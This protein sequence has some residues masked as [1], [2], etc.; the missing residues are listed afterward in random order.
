[1]VTLEELCKEIGISPA[2]GK[3][4]VRLEK[5]E[6]YKIKDGEPVFTEEYVKQ[7][8]ADIQS[9]ARDALKSRRNKKYVS[10]NYLYH[11]YV[12]SNCKNVTAVGMLIEKLQVCVDNC[13]EKFLSVLVADCAV[14]LMEQ[15]RL[16]CTGVKS[17]DS[18]CAKF[19]GL[20][21]FLDGT[22]TF[23]TY[24]EYIWELMGDKEYA[25]QC[26]VK[27][28]QLFNTSYIYEENEDIL[29]LIYISG[30]S[31]GNRK[32]AG[33]YYTPTDVVRRIMERLFSGQSHGKKV[34]DPCCGT[35]NFL[36]QLPKD[37][38]IDE[39]Y[40]SDIDEVSVKIARINMVLKFY[41]CDESVIRNHIYVKDNLFCRD[42]ARYNY[43]IGNPPWGYE[44]SDKQKAQ[45]KQ[46]YTLAA[47]G[48]FESYDLF[49]ERALEM[50]EPEGVVSFILPEAVLN[51]KLH[52]MVRK[53]LSENVSIEYI[54]YLGDIF[55]KV[56]C[57]SIIMQLRYTGKPMNVI[58][59]KIFR[60]GKQFTINCKREI[61]ID[62]FDFAMTDEEY[63]LMEKIY[64][65]RKCQYLK[66][67]CTFALG[68]ITGNN[69]EIISDRKTDDNEVILKGTDIERYHINNC[70]RY[71]VFQPDKF[72]Q[73]THEKYYRANKKL[74]YRF[75][76]DQLV[77]AYDDEQRLTLNSCNIL[78]PHIADMDIKYILA[79]LN[80]SVAQFIYS[81]R[82]RSVK[83][84]KNHLEKLP[85]PEADIKKQ[86]AIVAVVDK[87]I[88]N[89]DLNGQA[90]RQLYSQL[91]KEIA[92]LYGLS[93]EEYERICLGVI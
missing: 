69:K 12:S 38:V 11:S 64:K 15:R 31:V 21:A 81:K 55:H 7:L 68:I 23:D 83:V 58:G 74:L 84:L 4:W 93:L 32:K 87:L 33:A 52:K 30:Q 85:I 43:V 37:C 36:L 72:Q 86:E 56:Q 77:F 65:T 82:F 25:R 88:D 48:D 49:L 6:P 40:G 19:E 89:S 50:L 17:E 10:G 39:V 24:D 59:M 61:D 20:C 41:G 29:G 47:Q 44:F 34:I 9:G 27:Y 62:C 92:G 57:P 79:V 5:I 63:I 80:S 45:L 73:V 46:S 91:D 18:V 54:E 60:H 71:V 2:T 16:M 78:I 22:K 53:L 51:V 70:E 75:I 90:W 35:G 42:E 8:M 67:Q 14:K 3:N 13:D 1:M 66:R 28:P 26:L 76:S